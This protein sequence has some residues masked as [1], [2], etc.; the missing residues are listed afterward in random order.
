VS[1]HFGWDNETSFGWSENTGDNWIW[2]ESKGALQNYLYLG[3]ALQLAW[4]I[5]DDKQYIINTG[6]GSIEPVYIDKS[7]DG[8]DGADIA[9]S[10]I[11]S[12]FNG[13]KETFTLSHLQTDIFFRGLV[14]GSELDDDFEVDII[15]Y[16]ANSS[17]PVDVAYGVN[18]DAETVFFY[19][20]KNTESN[21]YRRIE[22]QSNKSDFKYLGF[23]SMFKVIDRGRKA[24]YNVDSNELF[25]SQCVNWYSR[26]VGYTMDRCTGTLLL[27]T[28]TSV[29][30]PDNQ[31]D[32]AI[33][34]TSNMVIDNTETTG[35]IM[36][37]RNISQVPDYGG[38]TYTDYKTIGDWVLCYSNGVIPANVSFGIG[39]N[40]FDIRVFD[41][42]I[43][44]ETLKFYTNNLDA[45]LPN[46]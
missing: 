45:N 15:L 13:E 10:I 5:Y 8:I 19:Q 21:S 17:E 32:S 22:V 42:E 27:I 38:L 1:L 39:T 4:D 46:I 26:G 18:T 12:E 33:I 9:T 41:S 7:T 25:M 23:E 20:T 29:E 14:D 31:A 36:F 3:D 34:L 30:G 44:E 2:A 37:W 28:Y 35:G 16:D 40:L 11:A 43:T 6:S 24:S